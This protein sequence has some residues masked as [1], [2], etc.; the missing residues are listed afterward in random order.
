MRSPLT[1]RLPKELKKDFKKNLIIF[2]ILFLTIGFV[3]G[4]F[5]ANNSMLKSGHDAFSKYNV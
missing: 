4:M 3:S 1:K 2:L 5:V